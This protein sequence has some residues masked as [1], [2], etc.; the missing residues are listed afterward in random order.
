MTETYSALLQ[1][2]GT[3]LK[4]AGI[5][6]GERDAELLLRWA[7]GHSGA[8]LSSRRGDEAPAEAMTRFDAA[9]TR[10]ERREP[11]SHI[12][13]GREFWGRWFQVTSDV[14]DPRPDSETMIAAA[15]ETPPGIRP[16]ERVLDLGTGSGCLIGSIL[17]EWPDATGVGIDASRAALTIAG[18]NLKTIGV[19]DRVELRLGDWLDGVFETFD[20]IL[21]NPPYIAR[22]EM[23]GLS[24]EVKGFEPHMALT[25]GGDGMDPYRKIA[26]ALSLCLARRGRAFFEIGPT[27]AADVTRI[28]GAFGW[29]EPIIHPDMDGRDRCLEY[30]RK[31]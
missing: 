1:R 26:P 17:A 29:P 6:G 21:C 2:G 15:L 25:P 28:F 23:E 3:R 13:G 5:E 9:I 19:S 27:Q 20:L 22:D 14:L 11:V 10:R 16:I 7:S 31:P 18:E 8:A 24:P 12:I 30:R 4:A